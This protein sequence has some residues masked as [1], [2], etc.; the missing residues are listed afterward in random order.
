MGGINLKV[1]PLFF[2][3]GFYY[4]LTGRIF[5]FLI[6]TFT[7]VVHEL[8]HSFVA[9]KYGYKLNDLVLMPFGAVVKGDL[10]GLKLLDQFRVAFAGP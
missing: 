2:L 4:A 7:A 5:L 8:G 6:C 10:N 1:H 9:S 3:F